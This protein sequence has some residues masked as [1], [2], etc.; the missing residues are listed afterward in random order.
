MQRSSRCLARQDPGSAPGHVSVLLR[1]LDQLHTTLTPANAAEHVSG[2]WRHGDAALSSHVCVTCHVRA[3]SQCQALTESQPRA[4]GRH[5]K[6][7][8]S[9]TLRTANHQHRNT[10]LLIAVSIPLQ[11]KEAATSSRADSMPPQPGARGTSSHGDD[12]RHPDNHAHY[13]QRGNWL[14]AAVLGANDGLVTVGAL[15]TGIGA[16]SQDQHQLLLS[17]VSALVAGAH[18]PLQIPLACY[19]YDRAASFVVATSHV[20]MR[21]SR[22]AQDRAG[23]QS[24]TLRLWLQG[25]CPWR[26]ASTCR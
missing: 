4:H 19:W 21:R 15:L 25:R 7:V 18:F 1:A 3:L 22:R 10:S 24:A 26:R 9:S 16:A 14:R 6:L 8:A 11:P 5:C 12:P 23:R 13:S 20:R 2:C 17:A